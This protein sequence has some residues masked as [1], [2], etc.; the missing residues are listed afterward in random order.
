MFKAI[1][2]YQLET[3]VYILLLDLWLNRRIVQFQTRLEN[4]RIA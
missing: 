3:E 1:P 2:I 4:S